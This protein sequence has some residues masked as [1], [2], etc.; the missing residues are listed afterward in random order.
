MQKG[1]MITNHGQDSCWWDSSGSCALPCGSAGTERFA[2]QWIERVARTPG[3]FALY[4]TDQGYHA[5][6]VS[7]RVDSRSAEALQLM[8]GLHCDE[9]SGQGQR[10][11]W[12]QCLD[13]S[14]PSQVLH[15][16]T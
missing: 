13:W 9:W 10:R 3:R 12:L 1:N 8:H 7:H 15:A 14:T 16:E 2:S 11:P 5:F 4:R 6:L